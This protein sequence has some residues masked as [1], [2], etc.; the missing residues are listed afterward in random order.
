MTTTLGNTHPSFP[1]FSEYLV[2]TYPYVNRSSVENLVSLGKREWIE[3]F[4]DAGSSQDVIFEGDVESLFEYVQG[5][6][7]F[8]DYYRYCQNQFYDKNPEFAL[9]VIKV[10]WRNHAILP[11]LIIQSKDGKDFFTKSELTEL[12]FVRLTK[13]LSSFSELMELCLHVN[14]NSIEKETGDT[15]LHKSLMF[16]E[17]AVTFKLVSRGFNKFH[18]RNHKG[19]SLLSLCFNESTWNLLLSHCTSVSDETETKSLEL[20]SQEETLPTVAKATSTSSSTTTSTRTSITTM[21]TS[22][23]TMTTSSTTMT[24]SSTTMTTSSTTMTTSS[25]TITS[26]STTKNTKTTKVTATTEQLSNSPRVSSL[27]NATRAPRSSRSIPSNANP[28]TNTNTDT[29]TNTGTDTNGMQVHPLLE[30]FLRSC[31]SSSNKPIHIPS[32]VNSFFD[33]N[34]SIIP[35]PLCPK[36]Q[37]T[38]YEYELHMGITHKNSNRLHHL[39]NEHIA[40]WEVLAGYMDSLSLI[41]FFQ[42]CHDSVLLEASRPS[43]W[44]VHVTLKRP[45]LVCDLCLRTYSEDSNICDVHWSTPTYLF[46]CCQ[47]GIGSRGCLLLKHKSKP[48]ESKMK[49]RKIIEAERRWDMSY[50]GWD[51]SGPHAKTVLDNLVHRISDGYVIC[52]Q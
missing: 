3:K 38:L 23:T 16:K 1:K 8:S 27:R 26:N 22:S 48:C 19:L 35:C 18:Q 20:P 39:F 12:L 34:Q 42:T 28:K 11:N 49:A 10:Y 36:N 45:N 7:A 13:K 46:T 15:F 43:I 37:M 21:T 32:C 2:S 4:F 17:E 29:N 25:M 47:A 31:S 30:D 50:Y 51:P 52:N 5:K 44:D 6:A 14:V 41:C 40:V 33:I 9:K 24:T